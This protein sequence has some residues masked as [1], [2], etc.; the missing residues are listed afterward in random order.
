MNKGFRSFLHCCLSTHHSQV[1]CEVL[2]IQSEC[3]PFRKSQVRETDPRT[4]SETVGRCW[5]HRGWESELSAEAE[6]LWEPL[7]GLV[8]KRMRPEELEGVREVAR[9]K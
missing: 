9:P 7:K 2:A 8:G 4:V 3:S 5:R 6:T 1:L